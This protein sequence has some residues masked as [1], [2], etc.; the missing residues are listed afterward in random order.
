MSKGLHHGHGEV[1][2]LMM[3]CTVEAEWP[4]LDRMCRRLEQDSRVVVPYGER[5]ADFKPWEGI[6]TSLDCL[7]TKVASVYPGLAH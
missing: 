7:Q 3:D 2:M 6:I 1:G 4:K 5:E